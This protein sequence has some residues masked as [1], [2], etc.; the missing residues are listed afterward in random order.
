M[1]SPRTRFLATLS[2]L[3]LITPA[4]AVA[5]PDD[6]KHIAT[7]THVDSPK[8]FWENNDFVLKS[9]FGGQEPPIADT[10]AWVGKGY[11]ATDNSN[12]YLYTLPANGTQDYIGAPGTTYYT[13]PHQVSGNTSPIWLGFGADT[14]LPTDKFRDGVAFLDLLSVD[15]P[16]E[17]ELFTNKDDEA[18]TQ[19]HR[20]LGSFPD[21]PHSA[22]LVAGTH[23]HNSTLFTKPG[24][25]R[26]T[27]RTSARGRDGQLIANEPQT[28]TIQVGGQKPKEEKT[29]SLKERFAQSAAGNAAA[30]GYSLRMA[31]KSK[32]EKDGDD[33]LTTI[34]FDAK[35]K[36]QGTLTLLIDGYFLTD[37]PVK[38]GHAQWDEY[39]GPD[40]SQVQAVFTPEGDAP[41]WISQP[42]DFQPG[43]SSHT[44]SS[45]AADTWQETSQPRQLAPT[46]ETE[47]KELGYTIR[48]RKQG[49]G[50]TKIVVD[51]E[52]KNFNGLLTGG[53]YD[54]KGAKYPTVD[55]ETPITNG[56]GEVSFDE[57]E[58]FKGY[59]AK[60]DLFPHSTLKAGHASSVITESFAF[61]ENYEVN[62]KF[63]TSTDEPETTPGEQDT[64]SSAPQP[65]T[66]KPQTGNAQC[67]EKYLLDRGHVDI[68]AQPAEG[69]FATVL[70]DDTAQVDKKSVDRKL[71]DVVLGVHDNALT[72]R[73][74]K[75][76]G[77]EFDFLGKP[78]ERFYHLPQTQ[79]QNI[80][81]PGYNTQDLDYSL[82]KDNAVNLNL[83]P[84][85][86]PDGAEWGAFIDGTHGKGFSVLANSAAKDY[87]IETNF[88]AHTHTHWAFSK[89][90]LY[91]FE[92]TYT[93]TGTD[94]KELKSAPQ[95]LTFAVGDKTLD[96]CSFRAPGTSGSGEPS[97]SPTDKPSAEPSQDPSTKP[98]SPDT[99]DK[100]AHPG[101]PE[102]PTGS[103]FSPWSLVL[104]AVLVVVFK[105]FYNFFRDN[106]DLIRKRFGL[107][108]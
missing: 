105:A 28:T 29:P 93:A 54:T 86:T 6:G 24:R 61:G 97:E 56:H 103:S 50:G 71:D 62:G 37:L 79:D 94:G 20:M 68:K 87:T 17:V 96:S 4:T 15:G 75:L 49:D 89:P 84:T 107:N 70:R 30:A 23:T 65:G 60:V 104:P 72:P 76:A 13:A 88:P 1:A 81:W 7:N 69:G 16:G 82:T 101:R 92:A 51:T 47:L 21:S 33:K 5:G 55:L 95:T 77:K 32:P 43:K 18:G 64:P 31:P 34:S 11:S 35:N 66:E 100:P 27:Y 52:D 42:L 58:Y 85:S 99:P 46:Q 40:P 53:L 3:A 26:L 48:M 25:Y 63:S 83:K 59:F 9:E 106:E 14:S 36:A 41:R 38:D 102:E 98:S 19:L 2:T 22:Y 10:V 12:Q 80:I 44:D 108:F 78:G 91:T 74:K 8:S 45:A 90:G 67:S 57:G 73:N 39:M